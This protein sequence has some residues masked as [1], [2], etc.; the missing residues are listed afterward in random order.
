MNP[1]N[2]NRIRNYIITGVV[3]LIIIIGVV[4]LVNNFL[5]R[6]RVTIKAPKNAGIYLIETK[7]LGYTKKLLGRTS[8]SFS[9]KSGEYTYL[10]EDNQKASIQTVNVVSGKNYTFEIF[11]N[12]LKDVKSFSKVTATSMQVTG[13]SISYLNSTYNLLESVAKGKNIPS[14]FPIN[15]TPE[16]VK[17]MVWTKQNEG[18]I[19]TNLGIGYLN[20]GKISEINFYNFE[21]PEQFEFSE[22]SNTSVNNFTANSKNQILAMVGSSLAYK[23]TPQAKTKLLEN[24]IE[25]QF[26]NI[27]LSENDLYAFSTT[28]D[29]SDEGET[30]NN[31]DDTDRS[32][33]IKKLSN[34]DYL[35][36]VDS[37]SSVNSI[38]FN[39]ASNKVAYV[40]AEGLHIYDISSNKNILLYTKQIPKPNLINWIDENK[41]VYTDIE[42][43]WIMDI[44]KLRA[45]K[46]VGSAD[47]TYLQ[48]FYID[49]VSQ[50]LYYSVVLP[51]PTGDQGII[52]FIDIK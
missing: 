24:N 36:K 25:G 45:D 7:A 9:T 28:Q 10:I 12:N 8:V 42:G 29:I 3:L 5:L 49:T 18:I 52:N 1:N 46:V 51:N 17:A 38:I 22:S 33:F 27:A 47:I 30:T 48:S 4:Y 39:A 26:V 19:D 44:E 21:E 40:N 37:T 11:P 16:N 2:A 50:N 13:N 34:P 23:S 15:P 32:I 14:N 20:N 43:I 31:S 6:G 35:T 41:I